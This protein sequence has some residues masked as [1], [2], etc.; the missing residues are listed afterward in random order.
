MRVLIS[1]E[2]E[3]NEDFTRILPHA[4]TARPKDKLVGDASVHHVLKPGVAY[5]KIVIRPQPGK[6]NYVLASVSFIVCMFIVSMTVIGESHSANEYK[7]MIK[8][9]EAENL[10]LMHEKAAL[11]A[12][13]SVL[14]GMVPK[15]TERQQTERLSTN[16][17]ITFP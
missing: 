12:R 11:E 7:S 16:Q 1:F 14:E 3:M 4:E 17:S 9:L 13:I 10:R 2:A 6:G 8:S 5:P 15:S